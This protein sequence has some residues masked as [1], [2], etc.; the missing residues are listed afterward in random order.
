MSLFPTHKAYKYRI[1]PNK[2]QRQALSQ[3][4]GCV[5]YVYNWALEKKQSAYKEN[6]ESIPI[7]QL[8]KELTFLRHQKDTIWLNGVSRIPLTEALRNLN[9]AYTNFFK[10]RGGKPKFKSKYAKQSAYYRHNDIK[11]TGRGI[12]FQKIDGDIKVRWHR[13]LPE[14]CEIRSAV[15][16]KDKM[17]RYF[18]SI[19]IIETIAQLEPIKTKI[20]IDLGLTHF[21]ITSNGNKTINLRIF[22]SLQKKLRRAQRVFDRRK[23]G[24]KNRA[25]A[26]LR[27]DKIYA[28]IVDK[29]RDFQHKLSKAFIDE[30]Q[31]IGVE[32]LRI[33]NMMK[34]KRLAKAIGDVSWGEFIRMLEYKGKWYGRDVVPLDT[35]F[36]SSKTCSTCG[37]KV[38][39]MPLSIRQWTCPECY[40]KHD[41][42]I[43]AA[44]NIRNNTVGMTEIDACGVHVRPAITEAKHDEARNIPTS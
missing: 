10:R 29:R 31:A 11:I 18:V 21:A 19:S 23:K 44:I 3:T 24:S 25:K 1:Y 20:G 15:V 22:E 28:K 43:N 39:D 17:G 32:K 8:S 41:R 12:K 16:S 36:P 38:D 6:G 37:H 35:F 4:F 33:Q 30:N 2:L 14:D 7:S 9:R 34:N 27:V 13:P 26:K 42:D 40:T 5:R